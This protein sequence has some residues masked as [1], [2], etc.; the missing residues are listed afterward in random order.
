[1]TR[2]VVVEENVLPLLDA[3]IATPDGIAGAA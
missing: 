1:L 3:T 2:N